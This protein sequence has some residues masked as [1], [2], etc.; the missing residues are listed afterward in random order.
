[1]IGRDGKLIRVFEKVK[2]EGHS[3]EILAALNA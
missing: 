1:L 3:Q 2:L